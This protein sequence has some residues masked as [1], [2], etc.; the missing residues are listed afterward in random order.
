MKL[1]FVLFK[2][3]D[4]IYN[5]FFILYIYKYITI[6]KNALQIKVLVSKSVILCKFSLK[7]SK[8]FSSKRI[9]QKV[10]SL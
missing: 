9:L 2:T 1:I 7:K 4:S 3:I 8:E 6:S 10:K 5:L